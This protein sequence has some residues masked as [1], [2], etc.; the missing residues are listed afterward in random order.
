VIAICEKR[1]LYKRI[2]GFNTIKST[3][4]VTDEHFSRKKVYGL[5]NTTARS[6]NPCS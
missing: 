5:G 6:F 2:K 3:N 4:I 1:I